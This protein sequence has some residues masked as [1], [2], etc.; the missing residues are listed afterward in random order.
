MTS[1][2]ALKVLKGVTKETLS[3]NADVLTF[4]GFS[5]VQ[6]LDALNDAESVEGEG[7]LFVVRSTSGVFTVVIDADGVMVIGGR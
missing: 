6:V 2:E 7:R 5:R 1:D 4:S 3:I